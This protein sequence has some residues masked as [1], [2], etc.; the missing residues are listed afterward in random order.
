MLIR[1]QLKMYWR[2]QAQTLC[3]HYTTGLLYGSHETLH[4]LHVTLHGLHVT[5]IALFTRYAA[6]F[7]R[8]DSRT[9]SPTIASSIAQ[10]E[11]KHD[12]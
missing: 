5:I 6:L 7:T 10:I 12:L 2:I 8:Y 4:C 1:R 11:K 3:M 9:V